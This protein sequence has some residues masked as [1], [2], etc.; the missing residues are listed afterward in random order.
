MSKKK[1]PIISFSHLSPLL[2]QIKQ[3]SKESKNGNEGGGDDE[4][5]MPVGGVGS[6]VGA[7]GG[8]AWWQS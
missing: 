7:S 4:P 3:A 6:A 5:G 2:F 8:A 1:K